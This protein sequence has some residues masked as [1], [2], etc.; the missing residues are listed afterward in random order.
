M[1]VDLS[2]LK[3]IHTQ[4]AMRDPVMASIATD[5]AHVFK[6][7]QNNEVDAGQ[8]LLDLLKNPFAGQVRY[9]ELSFMAPRPRARRLLTLHRS[10]SFNLHRSGQPSPRRWAS[11][12]SRQ[13]SSPSSDHITRL[14]MP[15][16]SSTQTTSMHHLL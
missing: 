1:A 3:T 16:N 13:S 9:E 14:S 4:P 8:E 6:R 15:R 10:P 12:F 11:P 7:Q 2:P 5:A